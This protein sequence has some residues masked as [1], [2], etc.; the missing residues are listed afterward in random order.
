M[1][2]DYVIHLLS[3]T[4]D[5]IQ[6]FLARELEK[7]GILDLA[8]A[9]AGVLFALG[10][11]GPMRMSELATALDR[12]NSTATALLD[13]ME[14][15][16]YVIRTKLDQDERFTTAGLTEKGNRSVEKVIKASKITL[17]KLYKGLE[18]TE[19]AQF[20]RLLSK[21]HANFEN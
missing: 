17:N 10:K 15:L 9:H 18:E 12:T 14:E 5:R 21:I 1:R 6:K 4:R 20:M 8:P 3:R 11:N 2:A 7:Q 19:K 13:K 16:G